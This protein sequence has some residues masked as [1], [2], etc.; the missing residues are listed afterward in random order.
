MKFRLKREVVD[1]ERS[2]VYG[3]DYSSMVIGKIGRY[4]K[5]RPTWIGNKTIYAW[6]LWDGSGYRPCDSIE[7]AREWLV[8]KFK[9]TVL[10][11]VRKS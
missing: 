3:T 4:G 5:V 1:G 2:L 6:S 8:Q 9:A 10:G 7:E 11:E